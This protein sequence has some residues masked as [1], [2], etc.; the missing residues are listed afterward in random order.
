MDD[1]SFRRLIDEVRERADIVGLQLLPGGPGQPHED[2]RL[3]RAPWADND[4]NLFP[5]KEI[6]IGSVDS[7]LTPIETRPGEKPSPRTTTDR[8][9]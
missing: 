1:A 2:R 6:E 7:V 8:N 4:P 3:E 5:E 9:P